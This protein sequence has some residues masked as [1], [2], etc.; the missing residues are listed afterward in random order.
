MVMSKLPEEK[1][2]K[3]N[4]VKVFRHYGLVAAYSQR[5]GSRD[6][7]GIAAETMAIA[8]RRLD[9]L[10]PDDCRPWLIVTAR[11]LLFEEYRA[12]RRSEPIDPHTFEIVAPEAG[13]DLETESLNPDLNLALAA[14]APIDRE[15]LLLVAWE[16]LSPAE[17]AR[18]LGIRPA[19]FRVRLHRARRRLRQNLV[20]A[21]I[22]R[23]ETL[24]VPLEEKP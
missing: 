4:F 10:D 6:P 2:R 17:A 24:K 18:V 15:A 12:R 21:S 20:P 14:L 7:E 5:R 23:P 16:E 13:F 11:N 1:L 8:W 19:T 22:S 3:E 9:V